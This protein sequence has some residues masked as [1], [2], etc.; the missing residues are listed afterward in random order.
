MDV[1]TALAFLLTH[2]TVVLSELEDEEEIA[3]RGRQMAQLITDI[4]TWIS[5]GGFLPARWRNT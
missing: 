1:D 3:Q 2:A 4:D 5:A